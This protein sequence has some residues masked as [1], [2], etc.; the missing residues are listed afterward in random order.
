LNRS[1]LK[2]VKKGTRREVSL[3]VPSSNLEDGDYLIKLA[4]INMAGNLEAV[5]DYS[6]SVVRK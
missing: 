4:G 6:L 5:A 1:G 3:S 2:D